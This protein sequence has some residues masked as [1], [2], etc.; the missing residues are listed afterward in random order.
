MYCGTLS[1]ISLTMPDVIRL[2]DSIFADRCLDAPETPSYL[3]DFCCALLIN[4]REELLRESFA[5]NIKLLQQYPSQDIGPILSLALE[6]R[7]QTGGESNA[8]GMR[9]FINDFKLPQFGF[10]RTS[11]STTRH[12]SAGS[13]NATGS[14]FPSMKSITTLLG[15]IKPLPVEEVPETDRGSLDIVRPQAV[16]LQ[17]SGHQVFHAPPVEESTEASS[18]MSYEFT[19]PQMPSLSLAGAKK[20]FSTVSEESELD[21][22]A[23]S[24]FGLLKSK[25]TSFF[26]RAGAFV[27]NSHQ[28][29]LESEVYHDVGEGRVSPVLDKTGRRSRSGTLMR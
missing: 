3:T 15:S 4:V 18:R 8:G 22:A 10:E 24:R 23:D 7:K 14:T 5:E 29:N 21:P 11:K 12:E 26:R 16:R 17:T 1:E 25:S 6:L 2:W 28:P 27:S 13:E 20:W 9:K 19:R